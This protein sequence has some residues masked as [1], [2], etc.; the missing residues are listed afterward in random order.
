MWLY[1]GLLTAA[2]AAG[3]LAWVLLK[4]LLLDG[5]GASSA[6][7]WW[8][9]VA[10]PWVA[11]VAP[12][13]GPL[14]SWRWRVRL[15]RA[16]ERAALPAGIGYAHVAALCW[17]AAVAAAGLTA[18]AAIVLAQ[19]QLWGWMPWAAASALAGGAAPGL[20]L[21]GLGLK[22]RRDIER[23]LPFVFDMMTLCV[24]AGLSVQ[25]ALQMAAQS[26]PAG[27]LRDALADAL[28]EMRAGVSRTAAIKALAERSNSPLARNWAAALAQAEALGI[29][30]GPVLRAQAAQSRSDR[31][32]R[33]EQLAM[34]AP[35][36]MLLPLIGC[37]FP[38]TFIV[39]AFP[40][41][42]QLLQS[43]Q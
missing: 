39:L 32:T 12:L 1:L 11:A 5:E 42:V 9:R 19:A 13:A 28:A 18:A 24:E 15:T 14:C 33:A 20:W 10:W 27:A 38:C 36:K 40:I 2:L 25:G 30:L 37:I 4:P 31:H 43:V 8:W 3:W 35:V 16:I 34:Q 21:R 29:S 41:T 7:P 26:G 23:D 22:R 17:S 6:L